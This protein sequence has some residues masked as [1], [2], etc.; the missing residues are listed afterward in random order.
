MVLVGLRETTTRSDH[1][2]FVAE[3]DDILGF[4]HVAPRDEDAVFQLLR[5]YVVSDEWG[6]GLGSRLLARVEERL[7]TRGAQRLRLSVFAD[8]EVGVGFYESRGFER[9]DEREADGFD[10]GE[11]VYEKEL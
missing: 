5:I 4:V 3:G 1:E 11:Y 8:N 9:V 6:S 7:R 2:F 10:V